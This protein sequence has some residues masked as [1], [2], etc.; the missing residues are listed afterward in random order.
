MSFAP[1]N[2]ELRNGLEGAPW[3]FGNQTTV[4]A[5]D[6][7]TIRVQPSGPRMVSVRESKLVQIFEP[8]AARQN[9]HV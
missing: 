5:R 4:P 7:A 1:S 8:P 2:G 9:A 3:Y 6:I